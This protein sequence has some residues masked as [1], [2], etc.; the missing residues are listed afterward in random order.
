[1]WLQFKT[2][3]N[4]CSLLQSGF[5]GEPVASGLLSRKGKNVNGHGK[6]SQAFLIAVLPTVTI[7]GEY[8]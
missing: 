8:F 2:V 3:L 5:F 7:L 4:I 6:L 1:M